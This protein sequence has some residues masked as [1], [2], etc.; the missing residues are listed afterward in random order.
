MPAESTGSAKKINPPCPPPLPLPAHGSRHTPRHLPRA[1]LG[2]LEPLCEQHDLGH[3]GVVRDPH[4]HRC[5]PPTMEISSPSDTPAPGPDPALRPGRQTQR[6]R[7]LPPQPRHAGRGGLP[8]GAGPGGRGQGHGV[9]EGERDRAGAAGGQGGAR[10]AGGR[11]GGHGGAEGNGRTRR[12][13]GGPWPGG[14]VKGAGT[15][16]L[17]PPPLP[18]FPFP[19]PPPNLC[20]GTTSS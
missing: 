11:A 15:D 8:R 1:G 6:L 19:R 5:L 7:R 10:Q 17:T 2:V 13:R 4:G 12:R 16:P 3:E 9:P 20:R 18:V 14:E